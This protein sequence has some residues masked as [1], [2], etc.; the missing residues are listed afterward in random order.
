MPF[1]RAAAAIPL[2]RA[3]V[4]ALRAGMVIQPVKSHPFLIGTAGIIGGAAFA[5]YASRR[6]RVAV[7]QKKENT[8]T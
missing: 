6:R 1:P 3:S 8:I 5:C 2:P 4:W 7:A